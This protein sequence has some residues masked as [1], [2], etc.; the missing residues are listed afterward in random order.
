MFEDVW[1][2]FDEN[3][4]THSAAH[5]LMAVHELRQ[6]HGYARVSDI[7]QHLKITKG[8][9]SSAAKHLKERGYIQEDHNR[10]L[11]LTDRGLQVVWETEATRLT[12]KKFL[13]DAL[14]MDDDDA[15]IDACKVEHLVSSEARGRLVGFLR[16]LFSEDQVATDFLAAFHKAL[17]GA[18]V[19]CKKDVSNCL[20][21]DEVCFLQ[22]QLSELHGH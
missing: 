3:E 15:N 2:H 7:A 14:G 13:S 22:P 12:V 21:C 8:S 16:F 10:F 6:R 5:H 9:V 17:A 1:K 18:E 20:L 19:E 4:L 11:E